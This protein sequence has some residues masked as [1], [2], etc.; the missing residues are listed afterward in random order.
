MVYR[1]AK[2]RE[3]YAHYASGKVFYNLP[4]HPAFP[5]RLA[6]ETFQRCDA[7]RKAR[8]V[9]SPVTLYDP[10]CGGAYHLSILAYFHWENIAEI[11]ASDLDSSALAVAGR[12]ISLLTLEGLAQRMQEIERMEASFG[13]ASHQEALLSADVLR[14]RLISLSAKHHI[15]TRLFQADALQQTAD[16]GLLGKQKV[17]LVFIDIPYGIKSNWITPAA[18]QAG[19]IDPIWLLLENLRN[20][21]ASAAVVAVSALKQQKIAHAGYQQVGKLKLGKR[22][23]TMLMPR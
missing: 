18:I 4:G 23:V 10:C 11:I 9:N 12:N 5:I 21:L 14:A 7:V 6:S 2:E 22:Q 20:V 15:P 17:D 13:K 3:D 19:E 16:Q 8:G 1:F